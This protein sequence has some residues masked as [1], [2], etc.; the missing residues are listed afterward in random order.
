[1]TDRQER[2]GVSDAYDLWAEDYDSFDN[3]MVFMADRALRHFLD[4][5]RPDTVFE[6]GCGTGRNL[7]LCETFGAT[8][9]AGCDIS[10]GMLKQAVRRPESAAWTL[11]RSDIAAIPDRVDGPFGLVLFCLCLEHVE[12]LDAAFA[13]AAP[14]LSRDGILAVFEI[15]PAFSGS[16]VGAHFVRD[17]VEVHMPTF[18]HEAAAYL[19]AAEQVGLHLMRR[20]DWTPG[21]VSG[22]VPEKVSRRGAQTPLLL[23]LSFSRQAA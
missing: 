5:R 2:L 21:M 13:A 7:A 16:G 19:T 3:P 6:F 18:T 1:M 4:R 9:L 8:R 11:I 17:G 12:D 22:A 10:D 20:A 14:L 15:H 23:E